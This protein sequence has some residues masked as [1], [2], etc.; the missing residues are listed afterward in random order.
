MF[1]KRILEK[2]IAINIIAVQLV[3]V[4]QMETISSLTSQ[5]KSL[6][7]KRVGT[8]LQGSLFCGY[9]KG[10]VPCDTR[11]NQEHQLA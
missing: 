5:P 1:E 8:S 4:L 2:V 7:L 11:T 10:T 9:G 3:Q 6:C